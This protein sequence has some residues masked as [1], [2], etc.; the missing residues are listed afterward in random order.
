LESILVF[1]KPYL[2]GYVGQIIHFGKG[3]CKMGTLKMGML[4]MATAVASLNVAIAGN[5][6]EF[7]R[8][9]LAG[10]NACGAQKEL[11]TCSVEC[12]GDNLPYTSTKEGASRAEALK[13]LVVHPDCADQVRAGKSVC[14]QI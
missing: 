1:A 6:S 9:Y 3:A 13:Q 4:V 2:A 11:W 14:K 5:I 12:I 8:G 10:K 7:E